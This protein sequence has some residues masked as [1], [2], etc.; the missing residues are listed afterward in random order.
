[1]RTITSACTCV[2]VG[3]AAAGVSRVLDSGFLGSF[4]SANLLVLLIAL[5]AINTTTV[6]VILTKMREIADANPRV[7]FAATRRAMQGATIEQMVL[8]VL[9][10]VLLVA[11]GS[12][13]LVAAVPHASYIITSLLV[14][15]FVFALQILYDTAHAVYVILDHDEG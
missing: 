2:V 12:P 8:I 5:M 11:N 9:A 6:S 4:L 13:R 10:A 14:A 1:M 3:L 15:V 7:D